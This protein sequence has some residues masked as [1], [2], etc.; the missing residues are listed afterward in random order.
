MPNLAAPPAAPAA[1]AGVAS[2]IP[3]PVAG[4][5]AQLAAQAGPPPAKALAPAPLGSPGGAAAAREILAAAAAGPEFEKY[6]AEGRFSGK[7][8]PLQ[9]RTDD[10]RKYRTRLQETLEDGPPDFAGHYR[11]GEWGCGTN[12]V[13]VAV[14]DLNTGLAIWAPFRVIC[15]LE[16][17]GPLKDAEDFSEYRPDSRLMVFNGA[18]DESL[19]DRGR[20]YYLLERGQ[21]QHLRSVLFGPEDRQALATLEKERAR[22]LQGPIQ[23]PL[24]PEEPA[25]ALVA[26]SKAPALQEQAGKPAAAMPT[27][28]P[29][30]ENKPAAAPK[31]GISP[32]PAG[33]K[34]PTAKTP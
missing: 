34:D 25:A 27:G 10:D 33:A 8:A 29:E 22:A 12:C 17:V 5:S 20:H 13:Q 9:P 23:G 4:P 31:Q 26:P 21:W 30:S 6:P 3:T 19:E 32:Q 14:V 1:Q 18:R 2:P 24:A 7:A 16:P 28:L 15:C 11:V